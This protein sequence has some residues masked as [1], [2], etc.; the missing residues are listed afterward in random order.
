MLPEAASDGSP[1]L[2]KW[3]DGVLSVA[4]IL[5]ERLPASGGATV[6]PQSIKGTMSEDGSRLVFMA[7]PDGVAPAQLYLSV[8]GEGQHG[9][10]SRSGAMEIERPE[11]DQFRGDDA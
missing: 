9:S 3:D 6:S 2:Y 7:S 8:G 1:N 10:A 11:W 5:P 4:G